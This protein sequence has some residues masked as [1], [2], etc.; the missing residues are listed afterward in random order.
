VNSNQQGKLSVDELSSY[1]K[2]TN[3]PTI[4][5]EGP[6]D[7]LVYR[8][9]EET[10]GELNADFLICGGRSGLL[11]LYESRAD[12]TNS[13]IVFLADLDMWYFS[14]IPAD[15]STGLI[16]TSGYSIENDLYQGGVLEC[17]LSASER[18]RFYAVIRE[19]S[20]WFAGAVLKHRAGHSTNCDIHTRCVLDGEEMHTK[21]RE[22]CRVLGVTEV[23]VSE[24]YDRY[25]L[26]LRGK[27]L[28][29]ALQYFLSGSSRASK[30]SAANLFEIGSKLDNPAIQ[31]IYFEVERALAA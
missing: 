8:Y 16:F 4:I 11:K 12:F 13:K 23:C 30:Y 17:L 19:L 24:I 22:E 6:D 5:V 21:Y 3:L 27:N 29:Q 26:A 28:M 2:R 1:L 15:Y 10:L 18:P 25:S 7:A 14:G 31:R 20:E 9:L